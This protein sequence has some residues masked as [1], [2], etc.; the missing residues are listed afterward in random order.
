MICI[1]DCQYCKHEKGLVDGWKPSCD[2]F[3]EGIP[4]DFDYGAIKQKNECNNGIGYEP[5][6][7]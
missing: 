6:S 1:T 3:P 5:K 4:M 7:E 2:A